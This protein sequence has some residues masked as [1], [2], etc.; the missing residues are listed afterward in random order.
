MTP[1]TADGDPDGA[2]SARRLCRS[3]T[4]RFGNVAVGG[5]SGFGSYLR[6]DGQRG[7]TGGSSHDCPQRQP[8]QRAERQPEPCLPIG[9]GQYVGLVNT[10]GD[11]RLRH[12]G[13]GGE[14][15]WKHEEAVLNT[16]GQAL[17]WELSGGDVAFR[18]EV[19]YGAPCQNGA[20]CM[21]DVAPNTS[22]AS[23]RMDTRGKRAR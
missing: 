6:D 11:L 14:G 10:N 22:S 17:P 12:T 4:V 19:H 7:D 13:E 9:A 18:A 8:L 23:V 16:P 20:G 1:N 5:G 15:Y 21:N 2:Q 3:I